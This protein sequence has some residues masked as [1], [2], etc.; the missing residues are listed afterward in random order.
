[1]LQISKWDISAVSE[2]VK[3]R[4]QNGSR[5]VKQ[6][7]EAVHDINLGDTTKISTAISPGLKIFSVILECPA[8]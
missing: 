2:N 3:W 4:T 7:Q 5:N 6:H 1:M 8:C